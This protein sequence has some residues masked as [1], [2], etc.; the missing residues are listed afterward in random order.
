MLRDEVIG[1][2]NIDDKGLIRPSDDRGFCFWRFAGSDRVG[3]S[4]RLRAAVISLSDLASGKIRARDLT[5]RPVDEHA[6]L[7]MS[8]V[9]LDYERRD[10]PDHGSDRFSTFIDYPCNPRPD[11]GSAAVEEAI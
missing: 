9:H 1:I 11:P 3:R 5:L 8:V 6:M 2:I 4:A 7:L 10:R